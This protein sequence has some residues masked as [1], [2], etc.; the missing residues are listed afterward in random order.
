MQVAPRSSSV[1]VFAD[2]RRLRTLRV[3][4]SC[5]DAMSSRPRLSP[6]S[7]AASLA[8]LSSL[9]CCCASSSAPAR[10]RIHVYNL[11]AQWTEPRHV[12]ALG[13]AGAFTPFTLTPSPQHFGASVL[14]ERLRQSQYYEPD[15]SKADLFWIHHQVRRAATLPAHTC[16]GHTWSHC[17]LLPHASRRHPHVRCRCPF[18]TLAGRLQ[19]MTTSA[20][21]GRT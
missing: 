10:P 15:H 19:C 17:S 11:P 13:F 2:L 21:S 18:A 4:H 12:R 1:F 8:L 9:L 7:C 20:H 16:T 14:F 5:A 3:K 6:R